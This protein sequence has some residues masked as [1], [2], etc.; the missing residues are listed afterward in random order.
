[1]TATSVAPQPHSQQTPEE[2]QRW[3]ERMEQKL[4]ALSEKVAHIEGRLEK[5]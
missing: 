2:T 5:R 1:V 4:D 3:R